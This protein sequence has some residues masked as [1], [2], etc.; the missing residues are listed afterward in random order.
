MPEVKQYKIT[1]PYLDTKCGL[2][3][4]PFWEEER[5]SLRF[6]DIVNKKLHFIDLEKGPSSHKR[7]DLDFSVGTTADIEGNDKEFIFG[8][9]YGYGVM[10]RETGESR[11]VQKMW[12]DEER[13]E[14]GGGKPGVGKTRE[15]RMRSNDGA[16]DIN[17]R[18]WVGAMN[19]P[20]VVEG[21][22]TDEGVL[23]CLEPDL[24]IKRK[25]ESVSIPN[26]MSWTL[27][28][29]Y[30]YFTDSPSGK[31]I[32]YP[33]DATTGAVSWD[34]GVDFFTCPIE[35]GVPDGHAQDEEGCFWIACFGTG[36]VLRVNTQ[37]EVIAEIECPTRCVTCPG[38]CGTKLFI[39]SAEEEAPKEYPWSTKYQGA[40][41]MVDVGVRGCPL[42]KFK[43]A[44]KA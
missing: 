12:T 38:F 14:D 34:K 32:K 29:K 8:G 17:G 42:N 28:N 19:D 44:T 20:L 2:G 35:G 3:E 37:G 4:A 6:S 36:K 22:I 1:E 33:F 13:K 21:N 16:V 41:F 18:Y 30:M 15:E 23:F 27:D 43:M 31:I 5:N 24:S 39:T 7:F 40:L 11:W 25:K 10:N 9:K 26:G